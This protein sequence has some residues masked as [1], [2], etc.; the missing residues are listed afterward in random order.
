M[1]IMGDIREFV[2]DSE[3]KEI[4]VKNTNGEL[5]TVIRVNTSDKTTAERFARLIQ[6]L[7]H[8]SD[9]FQREADELSKKYPNATD[10]EDI[11]VEQILDISNFNIK[12]INRC[13]SEIDSV[14]GAGTVHNVFSECYEIN[15]D[16]VPDED[17]LLQFV[18]KVIPVM[19]QLFNER[20]EKNK[21]RYNSN[22]R[23]K[24]NKSKDE[25]I[26]EYK[27]SSGASE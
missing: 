2:L 16:Y 19:N 21:A 8:V 5:I 13:I 18:E 10:I 20:F 14:F 12:Y 24:H 7:D 3:I 27:E 1:L 4:A 6:N 15:Q 23:G 17:A 25:L 22:R 26:R 9:E 11:N